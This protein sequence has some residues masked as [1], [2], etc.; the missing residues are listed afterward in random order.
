[1][2]K[3]KPRKTGPAAS[4]ETGKTVLAA[5]PVAALAEK[6]KEL[7]RLA[8]EQDQLTFDDVSEVLT[9][10]FSTPAQLDH[11]KSRWWMPPNLIR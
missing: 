8:K 9:E 2:S 10:E 11:W 5:D 4:A 1:M 3:S 7:I 6:I